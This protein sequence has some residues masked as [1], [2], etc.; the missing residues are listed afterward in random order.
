[1]HKTED[2]Q[3]KRWAKEIPFNCSTPPVTKDGTHRLKATDQAL[4][5]SRQLIWLAAR[6][7]P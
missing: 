3:Q 1:M 7:C 2:T 4:Q 5:Y 6:R